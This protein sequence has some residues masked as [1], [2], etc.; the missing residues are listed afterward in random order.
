[1]GTLPPRE[2]RTT[3]GT[4]V[5]IRPAEEGDAPALLAL[6]LHLAH[7]SPHNVTQPDECDR[8]EAQEREWVREHADLEHNI[9]L[10]ALA[11]GDLL[12][13][14]LNFRGFNR[15]RVQHHGHFGIGIHEDWRGRGVGTHLIHALIDWA[16]A[17]PFMERLDLGVFASNTGARALYTRLG[18]VEIGRREREFKFGPGEYE[19]DI[20]M[21]LWVKEPPLPPPHPPSADPA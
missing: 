6:S 5:T 12:I 18:F 8:D 19:D 4:Q 2:V 21:S 3:D 16:R 7:T 9:A 1:M 11:P 17:H 15:R 20:Q 13:G 10:V 14:L